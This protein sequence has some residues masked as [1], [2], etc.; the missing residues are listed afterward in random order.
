MSKKIHIAVAGSTE[1]TTLLAGVLHQHQSFHIPWI[2]TPQPRAIGR[3]QIVTP[4]PLH[5]FAQDNLIKTILVDKKIDVGIRQQIE[6][7]NQVKPADYLL[8]VDFGYLIPEWLISLPKKQPL[9]V[10]PSRLPEWR[11]TSP[12]QYVLL[13]GSEYSAV[14]LMVM[15]QFFDQGPILTQL[16]FP[17]S[18]LDQKKYYDLSFDL[19]SQQLAQL[20]QQYHSGQIVAK[21]QPQLSPTPNSGKINKDDS[22][23]DWSIFIRNL[24]NNKAAKPLSTKNQQ[25]STTILNQEL[26][27]K[28]PV[29]CPLLT[30]VLANTPRELEPVIIE[31]ACRAF[32]R[33]PGV[34]TKITNY[35][36]ENR[37]ATDQAISP[38][39]EKRLKILSCQLTEE[40]GNIKILPQ[41]V[42]LEGKNPCRWNDLRANLL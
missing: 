15:N 38:H 18:G 9:N 20:I 35:P 14:T 12:G 32:A 11:G 30:Q 5:K 39:L 37:A 4:N 31:R 28:S 19:V 40:E 26:G 41:A 27:R 1:Y 34:W 13:S 36:R 16:E 29:S 2:L 25:L 7:A 3:K 24:A 17:T 33:W 42:Q 21:P 23:L 6:L 10:H 22:Q 8:V